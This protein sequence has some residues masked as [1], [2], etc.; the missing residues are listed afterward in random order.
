MPARASCQTRRFRAIIVRPVTQRSRRRDDADPPHRPDPARGVFARAGRRRRNAGRPRLSRD[1]LGSGRCRT[2]RRRQLA[3]RRRP[4]FAGHQG[5][6]GRLRDPDVLEGRQARRPRVLQDPCPRGR[7]QTARLRPH[8]GRIL[9]SRRNALQCRRRKDA[10]RHLRRRPGLGTD[11][12]DWRLPA[13]TADR[14]FRAADPDSR[15]HGHPAGEHGP[16]IYSYHLNRD[17]HRV[18]SRTRTASRKG[19]STSCNTARAFRWEL[20]FRS[21][22]GSRSR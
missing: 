13:R 14:L 4:A 7:P 6:G 8:R 2:R 17:S 12:R 19:I 20:P 16:R 10:A 5:P 22:N 18:D 9:H 1:G 21:G 3:R 11:L 15:G